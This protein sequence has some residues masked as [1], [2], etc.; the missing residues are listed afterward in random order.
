ML[1]NSSVQVMEKLNARLTPASVRMLYAT[2]YT[3]LNTTPQPHVSEGMH[4]HHAMQSVSDAARICSDCL[5]QCLLFGVAS[6]PYHMTPRIY[7][8]HSTR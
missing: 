3:R 2:P 6:A 5:L 8:E 7:E 4:L 1:A